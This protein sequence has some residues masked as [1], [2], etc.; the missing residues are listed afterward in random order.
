MRSSAP[1]CGPSAADAARYLR[2]PR[3]DTLLAEAFT[4]PLT[5]LVAGAGYGKSYAVNSALEA[6]QRKYAWLHLCELDDMA[7]VFWR[8]LVS[9]IKIRAPKLAARMD[10]LG[11]PDSPISF[12]SLL[13]LIEDEV[14]HEKSFVLVLDDFHSIR[15]QDILHF[16]E[17]LITASIPNFSLV[18]LSR[19]TPRL[20]LAGVLAKGMM[21]RITEEDLRFTPQ[22]MEAYYRLYGETDATMLSNLYT[23]TEGWI[24]AI[25]LVGVSLQRMSGEQNPLPQAKIDIFALI[26]EEIY[27]VMSKE[28]QKLLIKISIFEVAPMAL[29]EA[30]AADTPGLLAEMAVLRPLIR[31]N[32]HLRRYRLHNLFKDYLAEKK[33]ILTDAEIKHTHLVAAR[34]YE[35]DGHPEEALAHY[36]KCGHYSEIFDII[37]STR[38][39]VTKDVANA[40]IA[41]IEGAPPDILRERPIMQVVR[42]KYLFNNNRLAEAETALRSMRRQYEFLPPSEANRALLGEVYIL[43]ALISIVKQND[44]FVEFFQKADACLPKGS[45]LI[46]HRLNLAEGINLVGIRH[47]VAGELQ[48]YQDALF[49]AAPFAARAMNG[50]SYGME[51]LNATDAAYMTGDMQAAEAYAYETIYRARRQTQYG[52]ELI[53]NFYLVRLFTY[54][55]NYAKIALILGQLKEKVDW[56]QSIDCTTMYDMI[57]GWFYVK[58]G[59]PNRV[60]E[61]ILREEVA[62]K[63]LAP[64]FW[65]RENIVRYDNYLA[66][67]KDL[68]LLAFIR[69]SDNYCEERGM[70]YARIQNRIAESIVHHYLGHHEDSVSLLQT[71]YE[72]S[73]AN[74][75][76]LPFI[77]YG[78]RMR[79]VIQSALQTPGCTVPRAW[80]ESIQTKSSTYAKRVSQ[81][82][83]QYSAENEQAAHAP[84]NLSKRELEVLTCLCQGMT[85]NEIADA[86][87]LSPNTVRSTQQSVFSKLGAVNGLD[88]VRIATMRNLV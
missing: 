86:C 45:V 68:E 27:G 29:L 61:W 23:Y 36:R 81:I 87:A 47:P 69:Q 57:E 46:D 18:L 28:L 8:R 31:Y 32:P 26:E 1:H 11:Y 33:N 9:A 62:E 12:Y 38:N 44:D 24:L 53:A 66:A 70:L 17:R 15:N 78:S 72:L 35:S 34:W 60:A 30:L 21:A 16:L 5:L 80:L 88:A 85:K 65:G 58:I 49:V 4:K 76:I 73:Y 19:E 83:K 43:L 14:R 50:C 56:L 52:I 48:R 63:V 82:A 71:A 79:T 22:E 67:G 13:N 37:L 55:G 42:A 40:Y 6:A 7:V 39:H 51:Y 54:K 2:R 84:V 20:P 64:V 3:L 77:E 41:L 10:A 74:G 25:Y 75:L 59:R